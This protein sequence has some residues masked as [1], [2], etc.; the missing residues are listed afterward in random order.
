MGDINDGSDYMSKPRGYVMTLTWTK[1][2]MSV[3]VQNGYRC[4]SVKA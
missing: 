2:I 4:V 3:R 1:Q